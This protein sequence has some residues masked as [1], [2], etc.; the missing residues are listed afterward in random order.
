MT[1][2][3]IIIGIFLIFVIGFIQV[4]RIHLRTKIE[5]EFGSE[6]RNKFIEFATKYSENYNRRS[7]SGNFDG[8]LYVWLT[9][10]VSKIQIIVGYF[11]IMD[12]I[13]PSYI[14]PDYQIIINTIPKFRKGKIENFDVNYVDDCL[15]RYI[16]YIEERSNET[17]KNLKNPIIWFRTGFQE[18]ISIPLFVLNWFGIF[19]KN[20]V[21]SII[22]SAIYKIFTGI[23]ALITLLSGIVTIIQ[24]K[25]KTIEFINK[26]LGN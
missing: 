15:L 14:I 12:Y 11:G 9:K 26:I 5:H 16:G 17:I 22:E 20:R 8:E 1:I 13:T 21:N 25:E 19:S 6:Y 24:G 18:I 3:L 2:A 10:N 4:L 7:Q 23:I